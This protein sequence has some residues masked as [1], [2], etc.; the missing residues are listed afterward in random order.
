MEIKSQSE[1]VSRQSKFLIKGKSQSLNGLRQ[2]IREAIA[3]LLSTN[4]KQLETLTGE[5][6]TLPAHFL[7]SEKE[8]LEGIE[9]NVRILDP[10]NILKRGFSITLYNGKALKSYTE[11]KPPIRSQPF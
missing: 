10:I 8:K 1:T 5:T 2:E 6:K 9:K 11:V 7:E 4:Q 3:T